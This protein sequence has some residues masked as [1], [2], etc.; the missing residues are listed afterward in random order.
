MRAS[1]NV[2]KKLGFIGA[3]NMAE[4]LAQGFI[5]KHKVE[6]KDIWATDI[7]EG[8][9]KVFDGL[10]AHATES[11]SEV[12]PCTTHVHSTTPVPCSAAHGWG[13]TSSLFSGRA[14]HRHCVPIRQATV[15]LAGAQA[16]QAA[17]H[18]QAL[19]SVHCCWHSSQ[20]PAGSSTFRCL[21]QQALLSL[22]CLKPA[23]P[24]LQEAAG[25]DAR[26]VRVMPNTPV[27][28]GEVASAIALGEKATK[29]D[30]ELVT[31]LFNAVGYCA[32]V[33]EN[34]INAVTGV[35]GSGPAYVFIMI[36]AL[37]NGGVKAGL[38]RDVS[39]KLAAQTVLGAAKMVLETGKHPGQ[40]KDMVT[41]PAGTKALP[42]DFLKLCPLTY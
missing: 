31:A 1:S 23:V 3:G 40:L 21:S 32:P 17:H 24:V 41:S 18:R 8:R 25:K 42:T 38:P 14:K 30:S 11:N 33:P 37:A 29:E 26:V 10:G 12:G 20:S 5:S 2:G 28:V 6:A 16:S 13:M 34:L 39:Q 19:D 22:H 27:F 15:H 35:S 36:E 7:A 9:R 4:A